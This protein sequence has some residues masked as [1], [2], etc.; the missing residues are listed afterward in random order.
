MDRSYKAMNIYLQNK[1]I[2]HFD[3]IYSST[4]TTPSGINT[5]GGVLPLLTTEPQY[6]EI[7]Q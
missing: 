1:S 4:H 2:H 3:H 5:S 7:R 6:K